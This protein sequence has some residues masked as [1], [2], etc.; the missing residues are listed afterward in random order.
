MFFELNIFYVMKWCWTVNL[1]ISIKVLLLLLLLL[2]L[3]SCDHILKL[4]SNAAGFRKAEALLPNKWQHYKPQISHSVEMRAKS[5]RT[6]A[7]QKISGCPIHKSVLSPSECTYW[8]T[9][10]LQLLQPSMK[11]PFLDAVQQS[12]R[13]KF[14]FGDILKSCSLYLD[15]HP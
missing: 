5:F 6:W 10:L 9:A 8:S 12:Q 4:K 1:Y 11:I 14:N 15:F 2:T 7:L 13:F 3:H